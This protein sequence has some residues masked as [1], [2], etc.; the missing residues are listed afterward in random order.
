LC[1]P[2]GGGELVGLSEKVGSGV[3][4]ENIELMKSG[5]EDGRFIE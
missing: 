2:G 4:V 3:E 1:A 5:D